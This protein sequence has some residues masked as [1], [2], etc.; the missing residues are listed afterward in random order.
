M[1]IEGSQL[2]GQEPVSCAPGSNFLIRSLFF[3]VPARRKFLKSNQTELSNI[4][5]EFERVALVH[6]DIAF[7]LTQN[8]SVVLSL[9]KSTL[10]QR[11]INIFGKKLNEQL[12]LVFKLSNLAASSDLSASASPYTPLLIELS[13]L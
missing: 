12:Q 3:N 1:N 4:L 2:V 9:P 10:R 11:I 7:S 13:S 8:G 5:Q 6:E